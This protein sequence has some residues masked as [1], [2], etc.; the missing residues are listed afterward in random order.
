MS[1]INGL[2]EF[3]W[4]STTAEAIAVIV[5]TGKDLTRDENKW[6]NKLANTVVL[7]TTDSHERLLDETTLFLYF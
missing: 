1:T 5:Y 4:F 3:K 7:K 6:L 2:S